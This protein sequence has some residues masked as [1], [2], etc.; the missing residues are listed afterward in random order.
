M[1]IRDRR[2][3]LVYE[4]NW[5]EDPAVDEAAVHLVD[6]FRWSEE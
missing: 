1:C 2:Y 4:T 6:S 5:G 3:V